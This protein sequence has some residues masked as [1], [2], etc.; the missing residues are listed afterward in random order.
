MNEKHLP[1]NEMFL[2]YPLGI[3]YNLLLH[4]ENKS[5]N[6]D[7]MRDVLPYQREASRIENIFVERNLKGEEL[8]K[9]GHIEEAIKLYEQNVADFVDTPHPYNRLRIIYTKLKR[10]D[11]AIR[12]CQAYVKGS[13]LLAEA[14][15]KELGNPKL[16][17]ELGNPLDFADWVV[18]LKQKRDKKG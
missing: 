1:P 15:K 7:F 5:G 4:Y 11:D 14:I 18:K 9:A 12:V 10:Y 3:R 2:S 17:K 6:T 8:E 13:K 16:A